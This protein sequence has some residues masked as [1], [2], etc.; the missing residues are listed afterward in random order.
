MLCAG[1]VH[2]YISIWQLSAH[3]LNVQKIDGLGTI[4]LSMQMSV[5]P[6]TDHSG[7]V[8]LMTQHLRNLCSARLA[9]HHRSAEEDGVA[10]QAVA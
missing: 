10:C 1:P 3:F 9:V 5:R 8:Q 4:H 7:L 6:A 2:A